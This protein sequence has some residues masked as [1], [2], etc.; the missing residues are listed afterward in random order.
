[1]EQREILLGSVS[2]TNNSPPEQ[3]TYRVKKLLD[4][5]EVQTKVWIL[6]VDFSFDV[7]I[8]TLQ[9]NLIEFI[10]YVFNWEAHGIKSANIRLKHFVIYSLTLV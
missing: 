1:M 7:S 6:L 9:G 8:M 2:W 5:T 4:R 3:N 10:Y